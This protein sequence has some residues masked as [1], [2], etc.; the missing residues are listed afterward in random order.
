MEERMNRVAKMKG[1]AVRQRKKAAVIVL[2][3]AVLS[4]GGPSYAAAATS[5][6]TSQSSSASAAAGPAMQKEQSSV[7]PENVKITQEQAAA[8]ILEWFPELE[9][10]EISDV[11][12][13][14]GG[15]SQSD[16]GLNPAWQFQFTIRNGNTYNGFS[17]IIDAMTGDLQQMYIPY[18]TTGQEA[19]FPPKFTREQ[20]L[21]EA[22]SF[23]AKALPSLRGQPLEEE[24]RTNGKFEVS[25][26]FGPTVYNFIFQTSHEGVKVLGQSV[27]ISIDGN[28]K[29]ISF[30]YSGSRNDYP[31]AKPAVTAA[32][33][34]SRWERDLQL[35]LVYATSDFGYNP[36]PDKWKLIYAPAVQLERLNAQTGEWMDFSGNRVNVRPPEYVKLPEPFRPYVP[37]PVTPAEAAR[38]VEEYAD[39]PEGYTL[40]SQSVQQGRAGEPDTIYLQWKSESA[41]P[42]GGRHASVNAETGQLI[43][44]SVPFYGPGG[45]RL[46]EP[47]RQSP[48][49][50]EQAVKMADEWMSANFPDAASYRRILA[51]E[52]S[53]AAGESEYTTVSYQLFYNDL[54]IQNR[55]VAITF[56]GKGKMVGFR[57]DGIPGAG[58]LKKLDGLKPALTPEEAKAMY[59]RSIRMELGFVRYGD[60][61]VFPDN[62][63]VEPTV[64]LAYIPAV[65][66]GDK[67]AN[68]VLDASAGKWTD[69]YVQAPANA[70]AELPEDARR[71]WA[72]ASLLTL[73]EHGVIKPEDDGLLHPDRSVKV[74]QFLRMLALASNPYLD[75][76]EPYRE[77]SGAKPFAD[78]DAASPYFNAVQQLIAQKLLEPDSEGYL[79]PE[80]ELTRDRMAVY[81]TQIT[82]YGKLAPKL[83]DLPVFTALEDAGAVPHPGAAALALKLGLMLPQ[84]GRFLP[85]GKVSLA[86]L[87]T[88]FV[89]L[90]EGQGQWDRRLTQHN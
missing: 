31:S 67:A 64:V 68:Q 70:S 78:V 71:H 44:F 65:S 27:F 88:V 60:Y 41:D 15:Q 55:M 62:R 89:C 8:S 85:N 46:P 28:G 59:I 34:Q 49:P 42:H 14:G 30:N 33:A 83:T 69:F 25:P 51:E 84:D 86:Q 4:A 37:R 66:G 5:T 81:L 77:D 63:Y 18:S 74:G 45:P 3:A 20:A 54:P 7:A 58:S 16:K 50:M 90:A 47:S 22:K 72:S 24:T 19:T 11:R 80:A 2:A 79:H 43:S 13:T 10:A 39:I 17:G 38:I 9:S 29:I 12:L 87:A 73:L 76:S 48:L 36:D 32:D 23:M 53:A 21:E 1:A 75:N 6:V 35:Q 57:G 82:G 61:Y 40:A 26:L 56:N 52:S